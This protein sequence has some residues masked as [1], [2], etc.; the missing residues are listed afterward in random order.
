MLHAS[1]ATGRYELSRLAVQRSGNTTLNRNKQAALHIMRELLQCGQWDRPASGRHRPITST[2]GTRRRG[3]KVS[4]AFFMKM[5]KIRRVDNCA[6]LT[7]E[8]VAVIADDD[9]ATVLMPCNYPDPRTPG[10]E[11]YTTWFDTWRFVNGKA[12]SRDRLD[13]PDARGERN[14][15]IGTAI[16]QLAAPGHGAGR[17]RRRR[18]HAVDRADPDRRSGEAPGGPGS[19]AA[20]AVA[21]GEVGR[22]DRRAPATYEAPRRAGATQGQRIG[23]RRSWTT[24]ACSR[25][26]SRW[27]LAARLPGA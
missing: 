27:G 13:S 11:N 24:K 16:R 10:E 7:T 9:D 14:E 15:W 23:P 1:G 21:Q 8:V 26:G 2:T 3:S 17:L 19:P 12:D 4:Y 20:G 25:S 18:R 22:V 6:K 5:M